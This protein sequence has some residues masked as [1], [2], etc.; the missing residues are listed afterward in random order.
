MNCKLCD[1]ELK[2]SVTGL[3]ANDD[4]NIDS[5]VDEGW[6]PN[7]WCGEQEYGPVCPHCTEKYLLVNEDGWEIKPVFKQTFLDSASS[8]RFKMPLSQVPTAA[9]LYPDLGLIKRLRGKFLEYTVESLSKDELI[10]L[11]NHQNQR[12]LDLERR[13]IE[14]NT[15]IE[16]IQSDF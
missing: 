6:I 13:Q 15:E 2:N 7:F 16:E 4:D 12:I 9:S 8:T 1:K 10:D 14:L 3:R 11:I 5:A